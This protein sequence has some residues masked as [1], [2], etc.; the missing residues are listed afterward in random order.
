MIRRGARGF[1]GRQMGT[2]GSVS[3][4]FALIGPIIFLMVLGV[5]EWGR[6]TYTYN[7]MQ[8]GCEQAVRWGAFHITGTSDAI[9]DYAK[10]QMT[11]VTPDQV[12]AVID[13]DTNTVEVSAKMQFDF[14][15][16][17]I[18]PFPSINIT[19]RAKM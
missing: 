4:E 1:F 14:L 16:S 15:T 8:F 9:E 2:S 12:T 13:P 18:S 7:T 11:G 6:Y 19:A 17:L 5:I 3:V 10:A